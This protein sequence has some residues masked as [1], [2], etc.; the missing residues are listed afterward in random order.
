MVPESELDFDGATQAEIDDTM[1]S[2]QALRSELGLPSAVE[3]HASMSGGFDVGASSPVPVPAIEEE[4]E[5]ILGHYAVQDQTTGV[6]LLGTG[7]LANFETGEGGVF[8]GRHQITQELVAVK[9]MHYAVM[10][11]NPDNLE[12]LK[13]EAQNA[14]RIT[15]PNVTKLKDI[16]FSPTNEWV[17]FV[18]ER[19]TG[20]AGMSNADLFSV[21]TEK[22]CLSEDGARFIV[23]QLLGQ[24]PQDSERCTQGTDA[25]A[26]AARSRD[27]SLPLSQYLPSRLEAREYCRS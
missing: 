4:R 2:I 14:W 25:V 17:Y 9:K 21:V 23:K 6:G 26:G 19:A 27:C 3:M 18:M 12:R 15:H 20:L 16:L 7:G 22:G 11:A 8:L 13:R 24:Y 1:A 10:C 5:T